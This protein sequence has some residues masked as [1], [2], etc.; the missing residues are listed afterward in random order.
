MSSAI[1][2]RPAPASPPPVLLLGSASPRRR[3]ILETL[4]ASVEVLAPGVD[5]LHDPGD[6]CG[7]V[8]HNALAKHAWCRRRD[9]GRWILTADTVVEFEGRALGKPRDLDEARA[10][11]LGYSGRRQTVHTAVALSA[12]DAP[13]DLLRDVSVV[14]F[15]RLSATQVDRYVRQVRPLDRAGAYD[16]HRYGH[17]IVERFEGS[18]TNVMGLPAEPVRDWLRATGFALD[19]AG[20][21]LAPPDWGVPA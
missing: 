11:L 7:T 21:I 1:S 5:E 20:R 14:Q 19:P 16:I 9:P 3:L 15:Q 4:G 12:P 2:E 6:A 10:M 13:P 17:L 8:T 18:F